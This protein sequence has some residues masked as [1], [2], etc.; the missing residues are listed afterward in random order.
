MI[1]VVYIIHITVCLALIIIVLLQAGKGADM[2]AAF[3]GASRTVF[4]PRGAAGP[5]AKIT[6]G[7][8]VLF[9]LTCLYLTWAVK[10]HQG[11]G[12][13]IP[14]TSTPAPG[15]ATQPAGGPTPTPRTVTI[16]VNPGEQPG[17]TVRIP[18]GVPGT[19]PP[20]PITPAPAAPAAPK[21]PQ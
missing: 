12:I 1:T 8:A 15:A 5:M 7:A 13:E 2:G 10:P 20:A 11:Q 17:R 4:G 19:P 6:V 21:P 14:P 16:P 3:G 18:A 9:M